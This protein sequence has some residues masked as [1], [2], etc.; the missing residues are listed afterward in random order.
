MSKEIQNQIISKFA[1]TLAANL[2]RSK[3]IN[4][5]QIKIPHID[6]LTDEITDEISQNFVNDNINDS[7]SSANE[8]VGDDGW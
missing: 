4:P 1:L 2:E 7:E 5:E 6:D 3:Y 8:D